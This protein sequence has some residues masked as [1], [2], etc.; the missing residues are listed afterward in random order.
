MGN[1]GAG[2]RRGVG[3]FLSASDGGKTLGEEGADKVAPPISAK[4]RGREE[5]GRLGLGPGREG[6]ARGRVGPKRPK[7]EQEAGK[8]RIFFFFLFFNSFS[9]AFS[10]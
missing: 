8:K 5:G 3:Q 7:G 10:I 9:K 2:S 1:V 6:E 4:E